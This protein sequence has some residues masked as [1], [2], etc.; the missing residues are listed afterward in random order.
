MIRSKFEPLTIAVTTIFSLLLMWFVSTPNFWGADARSHFVFAELGQD[1]SYWLDPEAFYGN[2]FPMGYGSFLALG[3]KLT[4]GVVWPIQIFQALLGIALAWMGWLITKNIGRLARTLT[5]GFIVLS[6]A[7]VSM[8]MQNGYEIIIAFCMMLPLAVLLHVR[9]T[10]E[11]L[12]SKQLALTSLAG[13]FFGIGFLFQA[14]IIIILPIYV[15]ILWQ[16]KFTLKLLMVSLSIL[17]AAIW[18]VRNIFVLGSWSPASSNSGMSLWLGNNPSAV[19]G[20]LLVDPPPLPP[21]YSSINEAVLDFFI[22]QPEKWYG[23]QLRKIARLLEPTYLY[24][25]AKIFPAQEVLIQ[26]SVI[27]FSVVGILA[28]MLYVFGRFWVSPPTIPPVGFPA[29]VVI[30]FFLT[31]L[32][33]LA[34]QRYLAPIVPIALTVAVPTVIAIFHNWR[35]NSKGWQSDSI[36]S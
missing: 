15:A 17:P 34:E 36:R 25:D 4:G 27:A 18:S 9:N 14:K 28:F 35:S 2:Y 33:F 5:Y 13:A 19:T 26:Y 32:P 3:L 31:H 12:F 24:P 16:S 1:W 11:L 30:V 29:L 10:P 8:S 20:E 21:Q 7:V 23:L 6:P 22:T